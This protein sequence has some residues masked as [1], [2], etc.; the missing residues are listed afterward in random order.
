MFLKVKNILIICLCC[1]FL[2]ACSKDGTV[3]STGYA[4]PYLSVSGEL[5]GSFSSAAIVQIKILNRNDKF[6][7]IMGAKSIRKKQP[8]K[9][10]ILYAKLMDK[11]G[12][13]SGTEFTP[14]DPEKIQYSFLFSGSSKGITSGDSVEYTI[15]NIALE[16][17]VYDAQMTF[18]YGTQKKIINCYFG[19]STNP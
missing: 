19:I 12:A 17:G 7:I 9:Y 10:L 18:E 1:L 13:N 5:L 15:D 8:F 11:T 2:S 6:K 14:I 4:E 3:L 16:P